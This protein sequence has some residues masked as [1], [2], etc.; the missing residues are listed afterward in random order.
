MDEKFSRKAL[1]QM[2]YPL[3]IIGWIVPSLTYIIILHERNIPFTDYRI[4][5]IFIIG[6]LFPHVAYFRSAYSFNPKKT[7][8]QNI[9]ADSFLAGIHTSII[10]FSLIPSLMLYIQIFINNMTIGGVKLFFKGL[11]GVLLGSIIGCFLFGLNYIPNTGVIASI[12]AVVHILIYISY[13]GYITIGLVFRLRKMRKSIALNNIKLQELDKAKTEF[14]SNISHEF[15]TPLTLLISPLESIIQGDY[16]TSLN[17]DNDIFKSMYHNGVRL[18][19]LINNLLD[20]TKIEAGRMSVKKI[21][22]DIGELLKFYVSTVKSAAANK[23]LHIVFN[24]NSDTVVSCIDR[25]LIEKAVFNL[26]SNAFKFSPPES[27]IIVQLDSSESMYM[28]I[29][30]DEGIGIPEEKLGA[31][32]ERFNQVDSTISRKYGGTG[33]GLALVKEITELHNGSVRVKSTLHKGSTFIMELPYELNSECDTISD[34][35]DD[36]NEVKPYLLT[37]IDYQCETT[38]VDCEEF[39]ESKATVLIVE[40]TEDM[41]FFL[42]QLLEKDYNILTAN[43][44]KIGVEILKDNQVDLVLSDVMMP[45]MDGYE[46]TR[47]MKTSEM[48]KGIPVIL[49]TAKADVLMKIEGFEYGADDYL[50]KPFNSKELKARIRSQLNMKSLRDAIA[51]Q[52]DK[53]QNEV[54]TQMRIILNSEKFKS[55]LPP[56]LIDEILF[57]EDSSISRKKCERKKLTIFFSDIVGFTV[58]TDRM[59]PEDMT[60]LLND[61]LTEMTKIVHKWGGTI[62]KFIGDAIMIYFGAFNSRGEVVEA[63]AAVSMAIDMQK[64]MFEL[65]T[66]WK[67]KGIPYPFTIRCGINTGYCTIGNFGSEQRVDYTIIGSDVNLASRFENTADEGKI[68]VSESTKLLTEDSFNYRPKGEISLK[69]FSYSIKAYEVVF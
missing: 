46:L 11:A 26:I 58:K 52:R 59:E 23:G 34:I 66:K 51:T 15:R 12:I 32:F 20:F 8:Y 68:L 49:L 2:G 21:K 25:D 54:H 67:Q 61:Y 31:I 57:S 7:E 48:L 39:S 28:I 24:N 41:R 69:G 63:K 60:F 22:T 44:G 38:D 55:Y 62:D 65:Q 53:L 19:K 5:Y 42:K 3:R 35:V 50:S 16:G 43:N 27:N 18:L 6:I 47:L 33:I 13:F 56:Q 37:D 4:I 1:H 9:L 45:E 10:S 17:N 29:V 64:K 14:F 30:K 36:Y 40:D